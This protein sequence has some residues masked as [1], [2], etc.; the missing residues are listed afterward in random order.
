MCAGVGS[1]RITSFLD[2]LSGTFKSQK[3]QKRTRHQFQ[4]AYVPP[5]SLSDRRQP[6]YE[7][8]LSGTKTHLPEHF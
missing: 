7:F 8:A 2:V 1:R 5:E 3:V 6:M 4:F